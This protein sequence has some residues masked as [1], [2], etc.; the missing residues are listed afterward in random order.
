MSKHSTDAKVP[1]D[2]EESV[3]LRADVTDRDDG[4]A[5]C[6]IWPQNA[7]GD[8]LLT[9]WIVATEGSYVSLDEV[10]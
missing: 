8:E 4:P 7:A 9:K 10:R 6:T 1:E 2:E 3:E 5:E